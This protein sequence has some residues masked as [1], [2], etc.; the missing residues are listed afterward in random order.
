MSFKASASEMDIYKYKKC[1][2]LFVREKI[3]KHEQ[4]LSQ[5]INGHLSGN[6]ACRDLLNAADEMN[7]MII[8]KKDHP[9]LAVFRTMNSFHRSWFPN[10][11]L[12]VA[13]QDYSA[14]DFYDVNEMALHLTYN[15]FSKSDIFSNVVT[16]KETF[17]AIRKSPIEPVML[18]DNALNTTYERMGKVLW[19][20]GDMKPWSPKL[21]SFG[22][23]YGIK[24]TLGE[25]NILKK[26]E[27]SNYLSHF[28]NHSAK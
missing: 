26:K 23:Y 19:D 14:S 7:K 10:Y 18:Y 5:V 20:R 27:D 24:K 22:E 2:A 9:A 13:T 6:D 15:F 16:G 11:E 4:R 8:I 12:N 3:D 25:D 28:A 21:V 1:Y 17:A